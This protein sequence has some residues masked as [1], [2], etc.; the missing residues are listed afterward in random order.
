[1]RGKTDIADVANYV[2]SLRYL[3]NPAKGQ[4]LF[5][6]NCASCHSTPLNIKLI[7]N[8][9]SRRTIAD[10][11]DRELDL[12]IRHGRHVDRAGKK[13]EKLSDNDIQDIIA[14]I[15]NYKN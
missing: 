9:A 2:Y 6:K 11:D 13:V 15:R 8:A 7:G 14:Y 1:M 4:K 5:S 12:R 10:T 3:A